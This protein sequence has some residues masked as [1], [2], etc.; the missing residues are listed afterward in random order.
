M[1]IERLPLLKKKS[2]L[3]NEQISKLSG[4]P[5]STIDKITSGIT[6]D[7]KLST[8]RAIVTAIGYT[9]DDLDRDATAVDEKILSKYSSL[10]DYGKSNVKALIDN[11]YKRCKKQGTI[12]NCSTRTVYIAADSDN[13]EED[14]ICEMSV[15]K[16]EALRNAPISTFDDD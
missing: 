15:E 11:E 12:V 4:I 1:G 8:V 7:P 5:V 6:P 9:L 3:T 14:R 13:H 16:L 10:D 2:G